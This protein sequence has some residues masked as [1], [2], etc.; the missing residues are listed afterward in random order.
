MYEFFY[1]TSYKS[2]NTNIICTYFYESDVSTALAV[3][4]LIINFQLNSIA[5]CFDIT[6]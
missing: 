2:N 6:G 5:G 4:N 3:T 1:V